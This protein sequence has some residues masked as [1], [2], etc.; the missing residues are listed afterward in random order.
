[1]EGQIIMLVI[2]LT[3]AMVD[4]SQAWDGCSM[5]LLAIKVTADSAFSGDLVEWD[6]KRV[7][8]KV[9]G[10]LHH[11]GRK[12]PV[13][14]IPLSGREHR[15]VIVYHGQYYHASVAYLSKIR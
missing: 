3:E 6:G 14:I 10:N 2:L 1:M 5:I 8:I 13:L 15:I 9:T 4:R 11:I 7:A 12:M